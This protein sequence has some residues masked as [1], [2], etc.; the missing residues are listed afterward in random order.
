MR[1]ASSK[2]PIEAGFPVSAANPL[3]A[4]T[5]GPHGA[6]CEIAGV[7]GAHAR[8]LDCFGCVCSPTEIDAV[9]IG[10]QQQVIG[11]ELARQQRACQVLVDHGLDANQGCR[12][13]VPA[14]V[15]PRRPRR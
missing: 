15:C 10:E 3:A 13:C 2:R 5:L 14:R 1:A 12:R 7:Q 4:S 8:S 11:A 9:D 6:R